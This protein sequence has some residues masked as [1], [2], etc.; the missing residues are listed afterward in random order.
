MENLS[1]RGYREE[2]VA[3]F[4]PIMSNTCLHC[5]RSVT[6]DDGLFYALAHPYYGLLHR[7]CAPYYSYKKNWPHPQPWVYYENKREE[8]L[9]R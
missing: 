7:W 9:A 2:L 1:V 8:S 4:Y 5:Q 6:T 3:N